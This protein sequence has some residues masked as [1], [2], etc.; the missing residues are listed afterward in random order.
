[1]TANVTTDA[2]SEDALSQLARFYGYEER[3]TLVTESLGDVHETVSCY[4]IARPRA[5]EN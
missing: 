5:A 1:M 3:V 2:E 4:A